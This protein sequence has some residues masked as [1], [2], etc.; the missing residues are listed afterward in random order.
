MH[1]PPWSHDVS[2]EYPTLPACRSIGEWPCGRVFTGTREALIATGQFRSE[3]F[4]GEP[5]MRRHITRINTGER[6]IQIAKYTPRLFRAVLGFTSAESAL[7]ASGQAHE[8][9]L[10]RSFLAGLT[11]WADG[12]AR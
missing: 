4:P 8:Q 2:R 10:F 12:A 5:G 11:H 7:R 1:K 9:R 6:Q 3:W